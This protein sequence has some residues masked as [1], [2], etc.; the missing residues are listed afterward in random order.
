[1]ALELKMQQK[2]DE[3]VETIGNKIDELAR[4]TDELAPV[5]PIPPQSNPN[6]QSVEDRLAA[7]ENDVADLGN[8]LRN[9]TSRAESGDVYWR[10]DTNSQPARQ[11]LSRAL[12]S[13]V[14][15]EGDFVIFNRTNHDEY[16]IVN[17]KEH[18]VT[19]GAELSLKV[20]PGTVAVRL[21]HQRQP[22]AMHVGFP[23]Y[24]QSV[25]IKDVPAPPVYNTQSVYWVATY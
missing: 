25:D 11:E 2:L 22:L 7:L 6:G 17:G 9:V 1:M 19:A 23:N 18:L 5:R 10:F 15:A 12:S 13:T 8:L 24:Y 3:A 21:R 16:I 20:R 4:S 14:P